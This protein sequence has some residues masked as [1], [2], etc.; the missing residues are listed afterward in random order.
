MLPATNST[1][2]RLEATLV[3]KVSSA[4]E[5]LR[6]ARKTHKEADLCGDVTEDMLEEIV[7]AEDSLEAC[8]TK[9]S[10]FRRKKVPCLS[11]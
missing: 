10:G 4:K 2:D 8:V 7:A 1:S 9:L 5:R 11:G 6:M 3:D